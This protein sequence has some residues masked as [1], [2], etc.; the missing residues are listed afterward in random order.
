VKYL[1]DTDP[2]AILQDQAGVESA[3]LAARI[4]ALPEDEFAFSIVSFH[5]QV[6]GG[7]N[8]IAQARNAAG[9]LRGYSMLFKVL[10]TFGPAPVL[11]FDST[12]QSYFDQ[13]RRKRVRI[14]TMDLRI[15]ATALASGLTLLTR[16]ARDFS[17][18]PGLTFE[19]WT[20]P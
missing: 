12:A 1:L 7:N 3:R 15:A 10:T 9:I 14:G 5:E 16:N 11:P 17:R 8:Y 19:D 13:L 2:I 18:V 20:A 6:L 4:D